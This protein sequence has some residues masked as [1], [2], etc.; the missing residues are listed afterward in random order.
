MSLLAII[1]VLV[2]LTGLFAWINARFLNMPVTI[3]LMVLA[4]LNALGLLLL[5]QVMPAWT[6]PAES[7]MASIDFDRTLMQGMLG[8]LLF[9]GA[10]HVDLAKLK[11][12]RALIFLLA[13]LG[14]LI[15]T[16]LVGGAA[17]LVTGAFGLE[18]PVIYCLLFGALIAPTDPIAVLAI[19]KQVGAPKSIEIKLTGESLFNDGI[20]V[21]LF[22]GLARVAGH[23]PG[24]AAA[25]AP[26]VEGD[27]LARELVEQA[28]GVGELFVAEVGGGLLVGALLGLLMFAMLRS[29]DDYKT[30]VLITLSGVT[31]GYALC[32]ALHFSGPLA[33]VVAGLFIGNTGRLLAMSDHTARR[34]DEFWELMDEIL[35]AILFVLIGLE[36]LI[37]TLEPTYLLAGIA[38]IPLAIVGRFLSVGSVMALLRRSRDF[39]PGAARV[40][41]WAGLRGGISVALALSLKG[42]LTGDLVQVGDI[43]V[44]MTY[45]VVC[46]SIVVQGLTVAPLMRRLGLVEP[47]PG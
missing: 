1:A 39:T 38:V 5:Q 7:M 6:R 42:K 2:S 28:A 41:A 4:L 11:D 27:D 31:G 35:N 44:T 22:F 32:T 43:L 33:M 24:S 37:I 20:G 3:G 26:A 9:A 29:V 8:Y 36:V 47:P 13:T 18:V 40:L 15:T 17:W 12:Q 45:V 30:E 46:F 10:M 19:L 25:A 21:V 23:G 34:L 14:V 16:A